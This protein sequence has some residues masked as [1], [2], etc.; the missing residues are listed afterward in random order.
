MGFRIDTRLRAFAP[1]WLN[2]YLNNPE[3]VYK[4][5]LYQ[6]QYV[7]DVVAARANRTCTAILKKNNIGDE[8][9]EIYRAF[10]FNEG[11]ASSYMS[12]SAIVACSYS[13]N[14]GAKFTKGT[15]NNVSGYWVVSSIGNLDILDNMKTSSKKGHY[16]EV[17]EKGS[18]KHAI[19]AKKAGSLQFPVTG[20]ALKKKGYTIKFNKYWKG[21][22]ERQ[23]GNSDHPW[24]AKKYGGYAGYGYFNNSTVPAY[25][26]LNF[27][28]TA[29]KYAGKDLNYH[30]PDI[31][32][33]VKKGAF[34]VGVYTPVRFKHGGLPSRPK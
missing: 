30:L 16:W 13:R 10:A 8:D 33:S 23:F 12:S 5:I 24:N 32:D 6:M 20:T 14:R 19:F 3:V 18:P 4:D 28:R 1:K 9:S 31:I 29:N 2:D 25:P 17:L 15:L 22:S 11:L 21:G 27:I 34:K 26:A 7:L